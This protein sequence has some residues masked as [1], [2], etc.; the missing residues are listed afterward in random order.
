LVTLLLE[1]T[2]AG[3]HAYVVRVALGRGKV[4][5]M[6]LGR[7]SLVEVVPLVMLVD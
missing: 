7:E 1:L 4:P 2:A 5:D 3:E 6:L